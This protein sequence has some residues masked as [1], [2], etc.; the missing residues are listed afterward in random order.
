MSISFCIYYN[1]WSL[2]CQV[3]TIAIFSN[4]IISGLEIKFTDE[5]T[6]WSLLCLLCTA[7]QP[8]QKQCDD[9]AR[10]YWSEIPSV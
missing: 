4:V 9:T 7:S 2:C 10:I 1:F 6:I 8:T 5:N 3:K